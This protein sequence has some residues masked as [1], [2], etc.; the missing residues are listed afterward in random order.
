MRLA[1]RYIVSAPLIASGLLAV[2]ALGWQSPAGRVV[3][4]GGLPDAE[5]D[6]AAPRVLSPQGA[7][8]IS[9]DAAQR[10]EPATVVIEDSSPPASTPAGSSVRMTTPAAGAKPGPRST[11]TTLKTSEPT[12]ESARLKGM[13]P[14]VS[15]MEQLRASWGEPQRVDRF[16]QHVE[17]R[18]QLEPFKQVI[19]AFQ[20]ETVFSIVVQLQAPLAA[21]MVRTQL[22]LNDL[23]PALVYDQAGKLLGQVFPERGVLFSFEPGAKELQVTQI[24]L[25]GIHPQPFAIRA[26]SRLATHWTQGLKDAEQALR[27]D[28]RF[29]RAH[30]LNAQ[31]LAA[32]GRSEEALTAAEEAVKLDG[33]NAEYR[34]TRARLYH[35]QG[36]SSRAASETKDA[37]EQAAAPLAKARGLCLLA[38]LATA[39]RDYQAAVQHRQEALEMLEPQ[40]AKGRGAPAA[41]ARDVF[42]DAHL[43]TAHDIAWGPWNSKPEVVP[44]WLEEAGKIAEEDKPSPATACERKLRIARAALGALAGMQGEIDPTSWIDTLESATQDALAATDDPLRRGQLHWELGLSSYNAMQIYHARGDGQRALRSSAKGVESL[45]QSAALRGQTPDHVSLLGRIYFRTGAVHAVIKSS[46]SQAITWYDRALPLLKQAPTATGDAGRQ[47]EALVSM[48]VSYWE[49]GQRSKALELTTQGLTQMQSAVG[50]GLLEETALS[51]PYGNLAQ[52]HRRLGDTQAAGKFAQLASRSQ[53][54]L[55]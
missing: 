39:R 55:K 27:L 9:R 40:L 42:L 36:D 19:V 10:S 12:V 34:L 11:A 15:S 45:A 43:G 24:V 21:D 46:H 32:A 18:Y 35:A 38:D 25:E 26:E 37:I 50:Q 2:P 1:Y 29:A 52:M 20:G 28:P 41:A 47:G 16:P 33:A 17:H 51:V 31:L 54:S 44:K 13:Q 8:P 53:G 22:G 7:Q 49:V 14:G 5:A 3:Q 6:D 30:W 23:E 48:A 4:A